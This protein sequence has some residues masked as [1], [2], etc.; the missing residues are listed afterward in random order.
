MNRF[1]KKDRTRFSKLF[2]VELLCL[3]SI[4]YRIVPITAPRQAQ[5]ILLVSLFGCASG[6]CLH[7]ETNVVRTA[8][9][10]RMTAV[11][12]FCHCVRA[13][14]SE[15]W[16]ICSFAECCLSESLIFGAGYICTAFGCREICGDEP[17]SAKRPL[18]T[19]GDAELSNMAV[20]L[21]AEV[22]VVVNFRSG[23]L[24]GTPTEMTASM[25]SSIT[26]LF[27]NEYS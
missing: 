6:P 12:E 24:S 16:C 23:T 8:A 25:G 18:S 3:S 10:L 27:L 20:S 13:K 21:H 11:T 4:V 22:F 2:N 7:V 9:S 17:F 15:I 14:C 5:Q 26:C 19:E 1:L